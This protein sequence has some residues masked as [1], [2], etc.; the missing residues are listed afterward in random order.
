MVTNC[1]VYF[2]GDLIRKMKENKEP[3]F[4]IQ[5]AVAEL[6]IRKNALEAKVFLGSEQLYCIP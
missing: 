6:K 5:A 1:K 4:D 2:Q 3:V